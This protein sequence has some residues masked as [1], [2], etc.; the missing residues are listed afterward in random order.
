MFISNKLRCHIFHFSFSLFASTK[1]EKGGRK[2]SYPEGRAGTS[3]KGEM[4][5]KGGRRVNMLQKI[6][7][8]VSKCKND[9][10]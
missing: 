2:K 5:G 7:T 1:L 4:F 10:C 6:C 9:T 8:H 3:R